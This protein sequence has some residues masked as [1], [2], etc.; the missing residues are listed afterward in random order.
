MH[1]FDTEYIILIILENNPKWIQRQVVKE[2]G[3][4]FGKTNYVVHA[5]IEKETMH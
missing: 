3:L 4:S 2:L 5:P 1:K